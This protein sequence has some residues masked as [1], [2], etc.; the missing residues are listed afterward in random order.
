MKYF[1]VFLLHFSILLHSQTNVNL[2]STRF[3]S[4]LAA[5]NST[6]DN[7]KSAIYYTQKAIN[8]S[9]QSKDRAA[10]KHRYSGSADSKRKRFERPNC[11][12]H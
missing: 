3:Y 10:A 9:E 5:K 2:D 7:Y 4:N 1:L 11:G 6:E 12:G 8:Y